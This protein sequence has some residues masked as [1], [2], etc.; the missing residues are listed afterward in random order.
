MEIDALKAA[1]DALDEQLA[2]VVKFPDEKQLL[3]HTKCRALI[4]GY[5]ARWKDAPYT[6]DAVENLVTADLWNPETGRKSKTFRIGGKLD[7]SGYSGRRVIFDHK[8]TSEDIADPSA[9]YWKQLTVE[10]QPSQYM[11]LEWLNG[12]KV[13]EAVWDVMRKPTISPKQIQA[14][15][16]VAEIL[17]LGS[18]FGRELSEGSLAYVRETSSEDLEMYEAR[19]VYD[20]TIERPQRYYQRHTIPRLDAALH[21]HATLMWDIGQ[22]ILQARAFNRWTQ[23]SGACMHHKAPCTYLNICS[24]Y[25]DIEAL[26]DKWQRKANVHSELPML[27]GDGRD[28]LT[29]SRLRCFQT[30]RYKHYLQ[31]ELGLERQD[32]EEREALYFGTLWHLALEA[33][34]KTGIK[35]ES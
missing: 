8:T 17:R 11:L 19:L 20:C 21:K 12:R 32:E 31:Y 26:S 27:E 24:G 29:N 13:D 25:E 34:F 30:C 1:L 6:F 33:Y 9:S 3:I 14:K 23:N 15:K 7:C 22:E 18:Y 28:L 10:S 35:N 5:H 4:A 2:N 16:E